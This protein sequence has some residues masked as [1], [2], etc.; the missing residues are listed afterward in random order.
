MDLLDL[1]TSLKRF[2][3]ITSQKSRAEINNLG[4]FSPN[5]SERVIPPKPAEKRE[6]LLWLTFRKKPVQMERCEKVSGQKSL[7]G[8]EHYSLN[9]WVTWASL[10]G[11]Q[12]LICPNTRTWPERGTGATLAHLNKQSA[13]INDAKWV[14][15]NEDPSETRSGIP[16]W[17]GVTHAASCPNKPLDPT[18]SFL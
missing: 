16:D 10:F 12:Q 5:L 7:R 13:E 14:Q 2:S 18:V 3:S 8:E 1:Q 15:E 9:C 4:D 17:H 11:L 6:S